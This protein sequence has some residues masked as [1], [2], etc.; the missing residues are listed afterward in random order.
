MYSVLSCDREKYLF[1]QTQGHLLGDDD[2]KN[3]KC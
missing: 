3:I 2:G 1:G